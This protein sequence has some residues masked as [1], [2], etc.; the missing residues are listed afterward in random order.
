MNAWKKFDSL[1]KIIMTFC[2][3]RFGKEYTEEKH[4]AFIQFVKFCFVGAS[5]VLVYYV[6][7]VC[8]LCMLRKYLLFP[9]TDYIVAQIVG[10]MI[11]VFWTYNINRKFV[12]S[13][14]TDSYFVSLIKF[15]ITYS[16][17]GLIMNPLLLYLW[18]RMG[19]SEF[20]GPFINIVFNTPVNFVISKVWTFKKKKS[21]D[22]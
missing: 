1:I 15:Y 6:T 5:N 22:A 13:D 20:I 3:A 4:I 14:S 16:F 2:F 21:E 18:K 12:F 8:C 19:I 10:F 7:Y 9:N 11:S 17:T